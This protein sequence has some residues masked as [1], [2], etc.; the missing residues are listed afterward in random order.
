MDEPEARTESGALACYLHPKRDALL[1]C[2]RCERPI[3]SD[4]AIEA[5][6]GY[7]CP[8][9]AEGGQPVRRMVDVIEHAPLTRAL[10]MVIGGLFVIGFASP[11]DLIQTFGLRPALITADGVALFEVLAGFYAAP[12]LARA[13]GEPWLIVTSGFLH[14][15]LMHVGFNGLLLW[16]LGHL[17]EPLLGRTRFALLYAAG[18]VGGALGVV[19]LSALAV[20][21]NLDPTGLA[22][23]II[24]GSPFQVTIGASGA[25]FALMGAAMVVLRERGMN[26]WRTS[27][28]GL[29][30][31]NLLITFLPGISVGGHL[32]GL[33]A[34]YVAAKLLLVPR[35]QL[36][37]GITRGAVLVVVLLVATYLAALAIPN[38]LLG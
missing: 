35:E 37:R 18:L 33:A 25:V 14:A 36:R 9:C 11:I 15:N 17:L 3:C 38:A 24:G 10:V 27:I 7:Q 13:I 4:D 23:G 12:P 5:P 6:V 1:R 22:A 31:L 34:G 8:Q 26:P 28:G 32:G 16:Q 20:A 29:V 19:A 2:S 30:A 21:L